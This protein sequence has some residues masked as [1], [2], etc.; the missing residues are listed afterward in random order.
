ML[1]IRNLHISSGPWNLCN[2]QESY[3]LADQ[4]LLEVD[5]G[6]ITSPSKCD[7]DLV[8]F[9]KCDILDNK[10]VP[11]AHVLISSEIPSHQRQA[12]LR[13]I[14]AAPEL[15]AALREA[16]FHLHN[17]GITLNQPFYDLINSVSPE[18]E[19]ISTPKQM[20]DKREKA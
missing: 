12:N 16:A 4:S 19:P 14:K 7:I 9:H 18:V 6:S 20:I 15:L 11:I 2:H 17:A 1:F 8:S 5:M 10:G 13:L 3:D